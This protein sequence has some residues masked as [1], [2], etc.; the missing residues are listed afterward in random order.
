MYINER[1][2][3]IIRNDVRWK[4]P[5]KYGKIMVNGFI[6]ITV[7]P[8]SKRV[9]RIVGSLS[10]FIHQSGD[11][12]G[13]LCT[14]A[15]H[16]QN[17]DTLTAERLRNQCRIANL[18]SPMDSDKPVTGRLYR[19]LEKMEE[20]GVEHTYMGERNGTEWNLH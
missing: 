7:N 5:K 18:D 20:D 16:V 11:E 12:E 10:N 6:Y 15:I 4:M 19:I 8:D 2:D 1:I 13:Q 14:G 3:T 9:S 17:V